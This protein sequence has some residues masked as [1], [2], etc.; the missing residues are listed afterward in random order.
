MSGV[1][2]SRELLG[3]LWNSPG[4]RFTSYEISQALKW[5]GSDESNRRRVHQIV[6]DLRLNGY[7]ICSASESNS[8][9]W[10]PRDRE[11]A[12]EGWNIQ[13]ERVVT[14]LTTLN[15]W[16]TAIDTHFPEKV[17]QTRMF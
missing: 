10:Y 14:Q 9:Y 8:G 3:L 4:R 6:Q 16:K 1:D 7:P 15:R 2:N 17:L 13:H 12:L 11:D 5:N